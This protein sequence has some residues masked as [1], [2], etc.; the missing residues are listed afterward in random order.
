MSFQVD[1][2]D[3]A[4]CTALQRAA[5]DG[6]EDAVRLLLA[7][8]ADVDHQDAVHGNCALHEAAWK[9]YSRTVSLLA[10]AGANLTRINAGGFT[11]L[12]LC[13]QNGHNQVSFVVIIKIQMQFG[14]ADDLK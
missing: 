4:G 5:A 14:L 3:G 2:L 11:A 10:T 13:C 8:G 9:G 1:S 12:H 7:R 6:H